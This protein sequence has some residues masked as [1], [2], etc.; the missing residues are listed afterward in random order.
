MNAENFLDMP[1]FAPFRYHFY[2]I[3]EEVPLNPLSQTL[4]ALVMSKVVLH[5]KKSQSSADTCPTCTEVPI[6]N[7]H[8]QQSQ[9]SFFVFI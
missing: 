4:L 8:Q 2:Q 6:Y 9:S 7:H 1:K 3:S 5:K